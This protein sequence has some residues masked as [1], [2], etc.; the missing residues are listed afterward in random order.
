MPQPKPSAN[1]TL[2]KYL[3]A[4]TLEDKLN[5]VLNAEVLRPKMEAF[6]KAG[7]LNETG[8][9]ASAFTFVK[10]PEADSKKVS[11]SSPTIN[12]PKRLPTPKVKP[13]PQPL[14]IR[15]PHAP[16]SWRS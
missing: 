15:L 1:P 12:Q 13:N 11:F 6:Y 8:T 4:A 9:P 3:A 7:M 5:H 2:I 10:L 16:K 14:P